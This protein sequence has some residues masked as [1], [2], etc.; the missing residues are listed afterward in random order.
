MRTSW[1][2]SIFAVVILQ[3]LETGHCQAYISGPFVK[4]Q[5]TNC[6]KETTYILVRVQQGGVVGLQ[7]L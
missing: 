5:Y 4:V 1:A 6:C 2:A 7:Q 3:L